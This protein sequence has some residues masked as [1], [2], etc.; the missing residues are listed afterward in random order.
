[1]LDEFAGGGGAEV[2]FDQ[3]RQKIATLPGLLEN[4]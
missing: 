3:D 1:M 4:E 2:S